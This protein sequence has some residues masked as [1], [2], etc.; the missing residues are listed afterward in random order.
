MVS[1]K[2]KVAVALT[3]MGIAGSASAALVTITQT[4]YNSSTSTRRFSFR[5]TAVS[6]GI[7]SGADYLMVGSIT[8][9]L[10]DLMGNGARIGSSGAAPVYRATIDGVTVK[11]MWLA[12]FEFKFTTPFGSE[13]AAPESFSDPIPAGSSP[14]G[15]FGVD[16]VFDL[17]AGDT[18]SVVA[19][20]DIVAVP[21]PGAAALLLAAGAVIPSPRRRRS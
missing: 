15:T 10:T 14:L 7:V 3:A 16:L 1:Y 12:P 20:F 17:S 6:S 9:T 5:Q 13:S 2:G 21:G 18:A 4:F 11:E 8:A 19:T